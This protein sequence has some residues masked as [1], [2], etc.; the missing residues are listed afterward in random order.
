MRA[1]L[2]YPQ[3]PAAGQHA[4]CYRGLYC[5]Q[6]LTVTLGFDHRLVAELRQIAEL[7]HVTSLVW[8]S[9]SCDTLMRYTVQGTSAGMSAACGFARLT[10]TGRLPL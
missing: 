3:S 4:W 10:H 1:C 8:Q 7:R 9:R 2:D 5:A 6:Q